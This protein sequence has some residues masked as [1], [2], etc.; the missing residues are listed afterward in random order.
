M[1]IFA[2]R[3]T[4]LMKQERTAADPLKEATL[5][6]LQRLLE[7]LVGL[8]LDTGITVQELNQVARERFVRVASKRVLDETGRESKSRVAIMTGLPRSEVTRILKDNQVSGRRRKRELHPS[9]RV[10]A[11]WFDSPHFSDPNGQPAVLPIYGK[12]RSFQKLVET[13]GGGIPVRAMLDELT[14]IDAVER[15]P[16]QKIRAKTRVPILTGLSKQTIAAIG[17]RGKDLFETLSRNVNRGD[18]PLFEATAVVENSDQ[19][20][21]SFVRR[22]I[23]EQGANFINTATSLVNRARMKSAKTGESSGGIRLGV[24]VFYFQDDVPT[25]S[26]IIGRTGPIQRKNLRRRTPE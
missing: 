10:L 5:D 4:K 2:N 13:F 21:V 12:R 6:A 25:D 22:E 26:G 19:G 18:R 15:L 11:G 20:M 1:R 14:Q 7:P 3:M 23:S 16:E 24:T 17:E 9:R 8:M